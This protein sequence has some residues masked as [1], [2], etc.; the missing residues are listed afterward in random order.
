M[1]FNSARLLKIQAEIVS[2]IK[3]SREKDVDC[4]LNIT[5]KIVLL[6][7]KVQ[8]FSIITFYDGYLD[9]LTFSSLK[10]YWNTVY[11]NRLL[12]EIA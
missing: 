12:F 8:S 11:N 3:K 5:E 4:V 9:L 7:E 10:L 6:Y 1:I 2:Y